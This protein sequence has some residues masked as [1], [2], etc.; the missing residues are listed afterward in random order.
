M[1]TS[2]ARFYQLC[3]VFY[4][5]AEAYVRAKQQESKRRISSSK[6]QMGPSQQWNQAL[7]G[8]FDEYLSALGFVP[9]QNLPPVSNDMNAMDTDMSAYLQQDWYTG[10]V[11]LYGLVEQDI[12]NMGDLG[13]NMPIDSWT[14][15][16]SYRG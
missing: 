10:N 11:S 5:V 3:S 9:Q 8:E 14:A 13:F 1:L 4:K 16:G 2:V 7:T 6:T 15:D 12:N